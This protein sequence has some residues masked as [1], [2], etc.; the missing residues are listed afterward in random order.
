MF[1]HYHAIMDLAD[2]LPAFRLSVNCFICD[3]GIP[4]LSEPQETCCSYT[5]ESRDFKKR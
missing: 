1:E 5:L 2:C 3:A 4:R